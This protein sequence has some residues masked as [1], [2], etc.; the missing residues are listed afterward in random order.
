[1]PQSATT[2]FDIVCCTVCHRTLDAQAAYLKQRKTR[3]SYWRAILIRNYRTTK[4][5]I[6]K[7]CAHKH[8]SWGA[9]VMCEHFNIHPECARRYGDA[10][11]L[12]HPI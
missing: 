4:R 1:M 11:D 10:V 7:T 2:S 5:K 9:A 8:D 12:V 6:V 3:P